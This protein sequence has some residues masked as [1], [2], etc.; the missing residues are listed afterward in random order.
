MKARDKGQVKEIAEGRIKKLFELAKEEAG[1]RPELATR[2]VKLA[3]ELARKTQTKIPQ[4]LKRAFCKK[5]GLVFTT[6]SRERT[7]KGLL[8]YTCAKCGEKRRFS[9]R[10]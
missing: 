1:K 6:K 10:K 5:C 3:R 7:K 2:Y 4:E 9:I 8:V